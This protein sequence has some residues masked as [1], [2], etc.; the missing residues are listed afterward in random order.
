V[1]RAARAAVRAEGL[2]EKVVEIDSP[3]DVVRSMN[4]GGIGEP[5]QVRAVALCRG[6]DSNPHRSDKKEND[7]ARANQSC[8]LHGKSLLLR[9]LYW[10]ASS[11]AWRG[12]ER[13]VV[14]LDTC[15]QMLALIR[16]E[17]RKQSAASGSRLSERVT[18]ASLREYGLIRSV[19]VAVNREIDLIG[20]KE[21]FRVSG[22]N[23]RTRRRWAARNVFRTVRLR[24]VLSHPAGATSVIVGSRI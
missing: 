21:Y 5:E 1:A 10:S 12:G 7:N 16:V 20:E 2:E 17:C 6:L 14:N 23:P 8:W 19:N 15:F 22:S 13:L 9:F 4:A 18:E 24:H 11:S 3:V